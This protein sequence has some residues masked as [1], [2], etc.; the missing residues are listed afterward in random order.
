[1]RDF[2]NTYFSSKLF[3]PLITKELGMKFKFCHYVYCYFSLTRFL[4]GV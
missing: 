3:E 1:M 2:G 4:N